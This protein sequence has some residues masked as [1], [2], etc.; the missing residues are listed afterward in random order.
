MIEWEERPEGIYCS[1]TISNTT[2]KNGELTFDKNH[3]FCI[4][5]N[6]KSPE[7]TQMRNES[8]FGP[9]I[10]DQRG[11]TAK[12]AA[13]EYFNQCDVPFPSYY[14]WYHAD[15]TIDGIFRGNIG[16]RKKGFL[17]SI[18][19]IAPSLKIN[20]SKYE[21]APPIG[22]TQN[23]TLNNNSEDPSRVIQCLYY[24]FFEWANYPAPRCNL[25]NVSINGNA[26]GVYS[27]VEAIDDAFLM[28]NF[29]NSSGDLYECQLT[30][31][32]ASW[33]SRWESK[34]K[35]TDDSKYRIAK[36]AQILSKT[37][38]NQLL[39]KLEK[40]INIKRFIRFWAL[41]I[42]INHTDGYTRNSNNTYVYFDPNDNKRATFIPTGINYYE[43]AGDAYYTDLSEFTTAELPRRLSRCPEAVKMLEDEIYYLLDSVWNEA[44]LVGLINHFE[45]QIKA[46][47]RSFYDYYWSNMRHWVESRKELLK[48]TLNYEGIPRGNSE[49]SKICHFED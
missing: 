47:E 9:S 30:D 45:G 35:S 42:I 8:R 20:T 28:R 49:P 25:A 5:I 27:H 14:E 44:A 43:E 23:I 16:V 22:L 41:E 11:L 24:K 39:S 46:A 10:Q 38:T 37:P 21:D 29:G 31:F 18:Y 3:I 1:P 40:Y 17:G 19:S 32:R 7:F 48:E 12:T 6:M 33:L 2:L 13:L 4:S 36:I 34:T 26:L 15:L